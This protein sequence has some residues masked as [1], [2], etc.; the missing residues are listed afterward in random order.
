MHSAGAIPTRDAIL[1]CILAGGLSRRMG[2]GDKSLLAVGGQPMLGHVATRLKPQVGDVILNA[3]GDPQRFDSFGMAVVPDTIDGFAGP[4]AGV[5]A[6]MRYAQGRS[7]CFSHVATAAS[8]TPFFPHDLVARLAGAA[9]TSDTI[10]LATSGGHRHPVFGL[11][12]VALADD[13]DRWMHGTDTF[14]VLAWTG[15]HRLS[16]VDFEARHCGGTTVDP[17]F[18]ANTPEDLLAAERHFAELGS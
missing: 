6:A 12:P 8:D 11:W 18:N 9:T 5:L 4:L 1:G 2:G 13:L 7:A 3:N 14:K 10:V 16:T 17:F 15:R